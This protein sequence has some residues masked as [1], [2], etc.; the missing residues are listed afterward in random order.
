MRIV[1]FWMALVVL[2]VC[3]PP[4]T[5]HSATI[6]F[7]PAGAMLDGDPIKD[8]ATAVG[9]LIVFTVSFDTVGLV[10][11]L[12]NF[13]YTAK[14]DATELALVGGFAG[15][16]ALD[17]GGNFPVSMPPGGEFAGPAGATPSHTGGAV[18]V[19]AVA[20][21]L[22]TWTFR[23]LPGLVNDGAFDFRIEISFAESRTA[24]GLVNQTAAYAGAQTVEVQPVA[25]P[26]TVF[27]FGAAVAVMLGR[28]RKRQPLH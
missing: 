10:G 24:A 22:D 9:A 15:G 7:A 28:K 25:E 14:W 21:A 1:L 6:S 4:T 27:L 18:A 16:L 8:I 17:V 3:G 13:K 12:E 2:L 11:P 26:A 5:A 23:V 20:H 19:G